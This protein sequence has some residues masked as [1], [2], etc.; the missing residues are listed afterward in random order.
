MM[1]E[2]CRSE[3]IKGCYPIL[4]LYTIVSFK[5]NIELLTDADR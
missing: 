4:D 3:E 2:V 5:V 1:L